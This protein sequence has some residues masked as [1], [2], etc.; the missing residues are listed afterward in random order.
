MILL[1]LL[2]LLLM[3]GGIGYVLYVVARILLGL[4]GAPTGDAQSR[5]TESHS[6]FAP[7]FRKIHLYIFLAF[8]LAYS[9]V[10]FLCISPAI[11]AV[12]TATR[13]GAYCS[14]SLAR[15]ARRY[16]SLAPSIGKLH[17]RFFPTVPHSFYGEFSASWLGSHPNATHRGWP[18]SCG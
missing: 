5:S 8:D 6:T 14:P 3:F 1:F 17:G 9:L 13:I 18:S 12:R 10:I 16:F 15:S 4:R 2:L 7:G 11:G